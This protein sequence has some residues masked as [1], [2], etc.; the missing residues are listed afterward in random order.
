MIRISILPPCIATV[1]AVSGLNTS[2]G[3]TQHL[4][5]DASP[6]N[7]ASALSPLTSSPRSPPMTPRLFSQLG[8]NA[9]AH[10][11]QVLLQETILALDAGC[12]LAELAPAIRELYPDIFPLLEQALH[13]SA[14][15]TLQRAERL[16]RF[17][18]LL[19]ERLVL[20]AA[21]VD[22]RCCRRTARW[23]E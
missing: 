11:R 21:E 5:A 8:E 1:V 20:D 16:Y 17:R 9:A 7:S 23:G 14:Q 12:A 10:A 6:A 2:S 3:P 4:P 19:I 13:V 18:I 15:N 22:C